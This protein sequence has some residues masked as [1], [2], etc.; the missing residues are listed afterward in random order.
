MIRFII[1]VL[2]VVTFLIVTLPLL[3]VLWLIGMKCP[4]AKDKASR[5]IIYW[6]FSVVKFI[7]GTKLV[8]IGKENIP[9][10]QAVLYVGN[11]RSYFDIIL[12]YLAVPGMTGYIAKKEML[13]YPSLRK[14]MKFIGCLFLDRDDIRQGM[15]MILDAVAKIKSGISIFI[16]PEGTRN[17]SEDEFLPFKAGSIK[18]GEKSGC[19]IIPVSI[20]HSDDVFEKH[21][22]KICKTTVVIEFG[23]PIATASLSKEEKR[24]LSDTVITQIKTMY[25]KNRTLPVH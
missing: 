11:H 19:P 2:F 6:A 9:T 13:R 23:E 16:F 22:P 17:K 24:A 20:N 12:S 15:Q 4:R 25:E 21:L 5:A 7:A 1:T 8:I 3:F 14:W 18:I 10:D